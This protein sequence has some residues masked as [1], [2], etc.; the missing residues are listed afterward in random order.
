MSGARQAPRFAWSDPAVL[1][2]IAAAAGLS[3]QETTVC[4]LPIRAASAESYVERNRAHPM[5]M[6]G[7]ELARQAGVLEEIHEAQIAILREASEAQ[8]ELR[9]HSPYA[10]HR[11]S[12]SSPAM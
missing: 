11:L 7:E 1:A 6:E 2:P 10:V 4:R 3:L 12:G 8:D 9:I 5:A